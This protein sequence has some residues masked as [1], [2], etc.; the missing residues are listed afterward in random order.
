MKKAVIFDMDG[1][2]VNT[3]PL[4]HRANMK[5]YKSLGIDVTDEIY[6][7]FIGNSDR[8]IIQ[9]IVG[10]YKLE[11]NED[12]LLQGCLDYYC[13]EFDNDVSIELMP[14][15]KD[16][17]VDLYNNGMNILLASSSS[18]IKIDRIFTR[19]GL[20]PYFS[21]I[22]SG[23]DFEFS[24][25]HPAIF[26]EAVAKSGFTADECIVIEDSTNGIKAATS[27]GVYCIGYKGEEDSLQDTSLANEVIH[28]FKELSFERIRDIK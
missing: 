18:K 21:H 14:G 5:F 3:E 22:I 6:S 7:T 17:I 2:V 8:N 24:K 16:L 20:Y 26:L 15:V 10:L 28:D 27:A 11:E 4:S 12:V 9:K 13:D 1:V 25:P 23:Q 19:F